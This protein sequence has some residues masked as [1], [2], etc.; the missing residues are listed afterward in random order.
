[1]EGKKV[2]DFIIIAHR[3]ASEYEPENT[4]LS[5]EKAIEMGAQMIEFDV[6]LSLDNKLISIHDGKVNRTTNGT[7][8]VKDK[9]AKEL[10]EL[11]AGN[12]NEIPMIED[13]FSRYAKKTKFVIELKD[14][15]TEEPVLELIKKYN[16]IDDVYIVSFSKRIL[17]N[18]KNLEPKIT[19]GLIKFLPTN[20]SRDCKYCGA[21]IVAVFKYFINKEMV[22]QT[23]KQG[24]KLF[25]CTVNDPAQCKKFKKLGLTGVV[26]NKPDILD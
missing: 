16:S 21:E 5:Y 9:T 4:F 13:I 3:G 26:T 24:L 19:T 25:A 7:G 15:Y 6:R 18:V 11:D 14:Y 12:G 23:N 8:K 17:K 2:D 1:M 22:E 10:K 20:I